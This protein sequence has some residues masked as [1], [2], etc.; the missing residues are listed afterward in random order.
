MPGEHSGTTQDILATVEVAP[1]SITSGAVVNGAGVDMAGYEDVTFHFS[2]GAIT[3]AGTL[4]AFAQQS[5]TS[6]SANMTNITNALI[7][8]T[9]TTPNNV[10]VLTIIRPTSR[11]VRAAVLQA[12]NTVV[13]GV[14]AIRSRRTGITPPTAAASQTVIIKAN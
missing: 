3:G 12:V 2:L 4:A 8:V 7:S 14:T 1:Q 9:N 10:M 6:V 13:T 5:D 11:Y